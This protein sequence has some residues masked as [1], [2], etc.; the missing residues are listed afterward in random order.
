MK[1]NNQIDC[2][3]NYNRKVL[4]FLSICHLN[5]FMPFCLDVLL[6]FIRSICDMGALSCFGLDVVFSNTYSFLIVDMLNV[7][8][9]WS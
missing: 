4:M 1:Y 9:K 5:K 2:N 6:S 8:W 7:V 3:E